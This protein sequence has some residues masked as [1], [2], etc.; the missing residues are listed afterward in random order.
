MRHEKLNHSR[1]SSL[2][3]LAA[4]AL[5]IVCM[6]FPI[7]VSGQEPAADQAALQQRMNDQL[8]RIEALER[9]SSGCASGRC[10]GKTG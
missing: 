6:A 5:V 8:R 10:G 2:T 1:V 7:T 4:F 9:H 3:T